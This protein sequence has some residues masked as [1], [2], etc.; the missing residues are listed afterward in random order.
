MDGWRSPLE[1]PAKDGCIHL[2]GHGSA[3]DALRY[4]EWN[5]GSC[6]ERLYPSGCTAT[7]IAT[8]GDYHFDVRRC[9]GQMIISSETFHW[10][11]RSL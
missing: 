9:D 1:V 2:G 5:G 4:G 7:V 6:D 8:D 11:V 3:G 10:P